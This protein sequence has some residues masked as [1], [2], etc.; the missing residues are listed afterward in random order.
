M[1]P[2]KPR[3]LSLPRTPLDGAR[4]EVIKR[5]PAALRVVL[6]EERERWEQ[7]AIVHVSP[8]RVKELP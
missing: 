8:D 6:L 1:K 7:G 5:F 4:C 2:L 3:I